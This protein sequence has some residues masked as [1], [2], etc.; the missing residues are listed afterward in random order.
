MA[1]ATK[2]SLQAGGKD[3]PRLQ[4]ML[5]LHVNTKKLI[6]AAVLVSNVYEQHGMLS[7]WHVVSAAG[8]QRGWL[9]AWLVVNDSMWQGLLIN[10]I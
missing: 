10:M 1:G 2:S 9:S 5:R 7:A 8:C 6:I 4:Y 3:Q